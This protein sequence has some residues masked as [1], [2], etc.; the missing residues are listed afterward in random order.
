MCFRFRLRPRAGVGRL[1]VFAVTPPCGKAIVRPGI[2]PAMG[3]G[4]ID[5]KICP[6]I[7]TKSTLPKYYGITAIFGCFQK[8]VIGNLRDDSKGYPNWRWLEA[9]QSANISVT[10]LNEATGRQD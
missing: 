4:K 10:F 8:E 2:R 7:L 3:D 9:T 5:F 1:Q 6:P